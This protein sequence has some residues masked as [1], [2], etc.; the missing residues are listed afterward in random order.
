METGNAFMADHVLAALRFFK[1]I[2][3]PT[4]MRA[5]FIDELGEEAAAARARHQQML[6]VAKTGTAM[7][8]LADAFSRSG[9]GG[10][11]APGRG[12]LL[13]AKMDMH[14]NDPPSGLDVQRLPCLKLL[15]PSAEAA[16]GVQVLDVPSELYAAQETTVGNLVDWLSSPGRAATAT[17]PAAT[18]SG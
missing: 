14:T 13:V 5:Q 12:R 1:R 18:G 10:D 11:Q 15:M 7:D 8:E 6:S 3:Q 16:D 4:E 9:A 17:C 2:G